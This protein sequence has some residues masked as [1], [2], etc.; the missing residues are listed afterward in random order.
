MQKK[1]L[2]ARTVLILNIATW[3]TDKESEIHCSF[4]DRRPVL[5]LALD[6]YSGIHQFV[7]NALKPLSRQGVFLQDILI[8]QTRPDIPQ[9]LSCSDL[10]LFHG[11]FLCPAFLNSVAA[12]ALQRI[13][14]KRPSS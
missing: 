11:E 6:Y 1:S 9:D 12:Q 2:Q 8:A 7:E 14:Y 5:Q 4:G 3:G 10:P 13:A